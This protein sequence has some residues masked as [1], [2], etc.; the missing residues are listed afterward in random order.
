[1]ERE[2]VEKLTS[3]NQ[4]TACSFAEKILNESLISNRWYGYFDVFAALLNH[5]NS[6]V[7]NRVLYILSANSQ[8][9]VENHFD[10][11]LP[12][13]LIHV[14]DEKPITARQCVKSL[15]L[16]GKF[17]P[18]YIPQIL[19]TVRNADLSKYKDTM[20]PLIE[21]DIAELEQALTEE[22]RNE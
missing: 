22:N 19:D 14:T 17:K 18:Q 4:G 20:R 21:R 2:I 11:I 10:S 9:D 16:I 5:K 6:F 15:A 8:W 3:K 1:M 12:E 13:F 7:R